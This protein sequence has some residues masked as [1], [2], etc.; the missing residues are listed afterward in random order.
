MAAVISPFETVM[1]EILNDSPARSFPK[2]SLYSNSDK[3][4]PPKYDFIGE[5]I[6]IFATCEEL[7]ENKIPFSYEAR[8]YLRWLPTVPVQRNTADL[9]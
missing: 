3:E 9:G 2:H 6:N 7:G 5:A 8:R 1:E 4:P